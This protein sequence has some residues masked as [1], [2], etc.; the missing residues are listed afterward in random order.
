MPSAP[1]SN[2]G[3]SRTIYRSFLKRNSVF[4]TGIFVSAFLFEYGF[5]KVTDRIW[6][7]WNK[8]KQW[9][10]IKDRYAQE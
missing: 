1:S 10:E 9:K 4:V 6:D 7:D 5:N 3:I 2:S 8:G